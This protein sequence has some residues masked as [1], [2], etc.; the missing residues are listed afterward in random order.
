MVALSFSIKIEATE[1]VI[2]QDITRFKVKLVRI[3]S[4]AW[5]A[6]LNAVLRVKS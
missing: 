2:S 3:F 6:F 5:I 1:L 4:L